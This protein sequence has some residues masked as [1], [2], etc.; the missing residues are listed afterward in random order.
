MNQIPL[1]AQRIISQERIISRWSQGGGNGRCTGFLG[2][3]ISHLAFQ[4]ELGLYPNLQ[5]Q[6]L[7]LAWNINLSAC[8]NIID[9][10]NRPSSQ[11]QVCS[12]PSKMSQ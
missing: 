6:Q 12:L 9:E 10:D 4:W 1:R 7:G 2:N 3:H 5:A 11:Q 8:A